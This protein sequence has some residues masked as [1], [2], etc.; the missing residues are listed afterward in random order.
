MNAKLTELFTKV[1]KLDSWTQ[2]AILGSWAFTANSAC[3]NA[4]LRYVPDAPPEGSG[5]EAVPQFEQARINAVKDAE[6]SLLPVLLAVQ[7]DISHAILQADGQIRDLDN[8]LEF[9]MGTAPKRETFEREFEER[10]RQGMKIG[11]TKKQ[12]VDLEYDRACKRH[13]D[14]IAK[15]EHAVRLCQ[16]LS[17]HDVDDTSTPDWML[18]AFEQKLIDKAHSRWEKLELLRTNP[19]ARKQIRDSAE[20]DQML[21]KTLLAEYN[22]VPGFVGTEP[23]EPIVQFEAGVGDLSTILP[24]PVKPTRVLHHMEDLSMAFQTKK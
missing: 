15:G 12:F 14:L 18:E 16:T 8:T 24:E 13:E 2:L 4:A 19:R 20:A 5:I 1:D 17:V 6:N 22:E 21:I 9:M 23:E 3:I 7:R 10:R 11:L